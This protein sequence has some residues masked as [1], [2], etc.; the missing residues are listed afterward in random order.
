MWARDA[1]EEVR[2]GSARRSWPL[3]TLRWKEG[4]LAKEGGRPVDVGEGKEWRCP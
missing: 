3:L 1:G 2:G 4:P